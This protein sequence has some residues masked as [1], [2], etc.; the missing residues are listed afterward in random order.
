MYNARSPQTSQRE[1]HARPHTLEQALELLAQGPRT[2]LAGGTDYYPG[3]RDRA[4]TTAVIDI[5]SIDALNS[6]VVDDKSGALRIGALTTWTALVAASLPPAFDALKAAAIE[7]GSIQIQNR[8]T[9][10]GNLCNASPAADGVPPLLCL[11]AEVEL[12]SL[13]GVRCVPLGQFIQGSRK[14]LRS[15][16]EI[17][18]AILIPASA[19]AG[20]SAFI[21]LGTR[22]YLV[23]SISMVAA[24]I[25]LEPSGQIRRASISVGSCSEVATRLSS[26]EHAVTGMQAC[27]FSAGDVSHRL[28]EEQWVTASIPASMPATIKEQIDAAV[29]ADLNPISDVRAT[30]DYRLQAATVLIERAVTRA[31]ASAQGWQS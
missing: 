23:I 16:D 6:I 3:L 4:P 5:T 14:T 19:C 27:D 7:V 31:V 29:R 13:S 25:E 9:L 24:N 18:T 10:A 8:A 15:A 28:P 26:F 30:G 11:D 22:R 12:T 2:I 21:K 1:M 17:V 20:H